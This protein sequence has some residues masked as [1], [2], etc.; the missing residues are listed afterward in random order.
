MIRDGRVV[1]PFTKPASAPKPGGTDAGE[2]ADQ[3]PAEG[4][5]AQGNQPGHHERDACRDEPEDRGQQ[6]ALDQLTQAGNEKA[7]KC[8]NDIAGTA[9]T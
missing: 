3:K 1:K 6:T 7:A 4:Q 5:Q 2:N 9:L 8:R